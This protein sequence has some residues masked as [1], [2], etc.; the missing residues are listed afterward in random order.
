MAN[1]AENCKEIMNAV[2]RTGRRVSEGEGC[3]GKAQLAVR[4]LLIETCMEAEVDVIPQ[5]FWKRF[6]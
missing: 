4:F 1:T 2:N 6:D 5:V 3:D